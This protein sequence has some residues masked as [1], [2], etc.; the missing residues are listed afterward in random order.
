MSNLFGVFDSIP[1]K[2]LQEFVEAVV[3]QTVGA[4]ASS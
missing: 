1:F 2:Q 4:E 3:H